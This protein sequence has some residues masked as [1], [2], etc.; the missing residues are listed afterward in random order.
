MDLII[1]DWEGMPAN[2]GALS[3]TRRGGFS[4]APYDDGAGAGGLNLGLH[5]QD[6]RQ[7]VIQNRQLLNTILPAEPAWLTQ[8]HGV[9]VVDAGSAVNAPEADASIATAPGIVC[10]IQTA[11][12]LP[13]LFCDVAGKVVGAAHAGWRG[14]LHGVL[15]NTLTQMR[16]AGAGEIIAWLGPAI[17]SQCFEVGAEVMQAFTGQDQDTQ[18]AFKAVENSPGKYLAD[19]YQLAR[20]ALSRSGVSKI[21]GGGFCTMT[22]C[23]TFYSYR[24]DKMTGRMASLIWIK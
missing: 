8:V 16:N 20:Y 22:D 23:N 3:T 14:L 6:D 11:D 5:V 19:I 12:C 9:T 24:R 4:L 2:I 17:G 1:P 15:Q 7:A 18:P 13:V 10:A 21:Y